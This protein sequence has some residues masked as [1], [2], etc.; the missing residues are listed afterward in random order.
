MLVVLAMVSTFC[1]D[2]TVLV[3]A[4]ASQAANPVVKI[5]NAFQLLSPDDS[6][7][8]STQILTPAPA[9]VAD[10]RPNHMSTVAASLELTSCTEDI[11]TVLA[12]TDCKDNKDVPAVLL[13]TAMN[14][15][16]DL[17]ADNISSDPRTTLY[18]G[19]TD[20]TANNA[21][22]LVAAFLAIAV[23][24]LVVAVPLPKIETKLVLTNE[25]VASILLD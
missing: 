4:S 16:Y 20:E 6:P 13:I 2:D 23:T 8:T 7:D 5:Y 17:N 11:N 12:A 18:I 25:L 24:L 19:E 15:D 14:T 10:L 1:P 21:S 22:K 9:A 3:R